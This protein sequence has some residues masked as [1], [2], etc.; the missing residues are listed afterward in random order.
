MLSLFGSYGV[1]NLG[2]R[3]AFH[4]TIPIKWC[5]GTG[6]TPTEYWGPHSSERDGA[7][8]MSDTPVDHGD[9]AAIIV[10]RTPRDSVTDG[11]NGWMGEIRSWYAV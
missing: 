8:K 5:H 1:G 6:S 7:P 9:S 3:F 4:G 10:E 11:R 2:P